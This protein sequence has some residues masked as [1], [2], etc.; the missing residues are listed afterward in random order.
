MRKTALAAALA[1]V[2]MLPGAAMAG[3]YELGRQSALHL[4]GVKL[5]FHFGQAHHGFFGHHKHKFHGK[6]HR[7][8]FRGHKRFIVPHHPR[9]RHGFVGRPDHRPRHLHRGFVG[10]KVWHHKPG[11][12]S[13]FKPWRFKSRHFKRHDHGHFGHGIFKHRTFKD[14][15][16]KHR[17][18]K[19]RGRRHWRH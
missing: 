15:G 10:P 5:Q 7:P 4:S 2:A 16:F 1:V 6:H 8:H 3:G 14:R 11:H 18:F 19:H 17:S 13:H 9:H 12:R